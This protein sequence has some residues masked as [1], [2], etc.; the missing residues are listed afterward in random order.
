MRASAQALRAKL[1]GCLNLFELLDFTPLPLD[2]TLL[3][4]D[5]DLKPVLRFI[6]GL[7]LMADDPPVTAPIPPPISPLPDDALPH[8]LLRRCRHPI[9]RRPASLFASWSMIVP[10]FDRRNIT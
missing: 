7:Q 8:R 5:L 10:S 6:A 3:P 4:R 9:T 2:L 1:F